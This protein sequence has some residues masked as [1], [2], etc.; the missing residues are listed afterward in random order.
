VL[1]SGLQHNTQRL[2]DNDINSQVVTFVIPVQLRDTEIRQRAALLPQLFRAE[3]ERVH[4]KKPKKTKKKKNHTLPHTA[5][6]IF[7][8]LSA[9]VARVAQAV[10]AAPR[11]AEM[12]RT[13][14]RKAVAQ[15]RAR[16]S[17]SLD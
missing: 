3:L 5:A 1:Q 4:Q 13:D 14:G 10:A 17:S 9:R 6:E 7:D 8:M 11:V 12:D 16:S 15:G 2:Q